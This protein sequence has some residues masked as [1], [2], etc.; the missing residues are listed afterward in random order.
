MKHNCSKVWPDHLIFGFCFFPM[1]GLKP[2]ALHVVDKC[3]TTELHSQPS[4]W[5]FKVPQVINIHS[6]CMMLWN[7]KQR[8]L[9]LIQRS[10]LHPAEPI[11]SLLKIH[12]TLKNRLLM[13][14]YQDVTLLISNTS[15]HFCQRYSH[16]GSKPENL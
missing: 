9:F 14:T 16:P 4:I 15:S 2:R 6:H 3:S 8:P 7:K 10:S 5:I 11:I 1:L 12:R 13:M